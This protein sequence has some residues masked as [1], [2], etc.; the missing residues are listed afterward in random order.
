M[1][2]RSEIDGLRAIAVTS[3]VLFHLPK[4]TNIFGGG[5]LGVDIFFVISGYVISLVLFQEMHETNSISLRN[6]YLRRTRRLIPSF[7]VVVCFSI[8]FGFLALTPS[9]LVDF[10]K[11]IVSS[12]AFF[13]N[14]YFWRSTDYFSPDSHFRPFLHTWSLSLEEQFYLFFPVLLLILSRFKKLLVFKN[15]LI[16]LTLVSLFSYFQLYDIKPLAAFYLLPFRAWEL[17]IGALTFISFSRANKHKYRALSYFGIITLLLL[18]ADPYSLVSKLGVFSNVVTVLSTS[19]VLVSSHDNFHLTNLLS[20]RLLTFIGKSS[21]EIYLWHFP[22]ISFSYHLGAPKSIT[23]SLL[24]LILTFALGFMTHIF[25]GD[26]VRKFSIIPKNKDLVRSTCIISLLI[27]MISISILKSDGYPSRF[28]TAVQGE[29][30]QRFFYNDMRAKSFPCSPISIYISALDYQGFKRCRQSKQDTNPDV[31]LLG[32][33]TAESLFPG[34]SFAFHDLNVGYY[35]SSGIPMLSNANFDS[36]FNTLLSDNKPKV[37]LLTWHYFGH[38]PMST[39]VKFQINRTIDQLKKS[40]KAIFIISGVPTFPI[41]AEKCKYTNI[42]GESNPECTLSSRQRME[43]TRISILEPREIATSNG[44]PFI[45]IFSRIC[46]S[47]TCS[48]ILQEKILYRDSLHLNYL[49]SQ[50]VATFLNST[51]KASIMN[52]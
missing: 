35:V 38:Y 40:N 17:M 47:R 24:I 10:A 23:F 11:S 26:R 31:V 5:F 4:S 22:L 1:A 30:G 50:I 15:V 33:S 34:L 21:Y 46:N 45:N 6:F 42:L 2:Y 48:M 12:L 9:A 37:V 36:I 28:S 51:F 32:D 20:Y 52:S 29:V 3:V 43:Q 27:Y 41:D 39:S 8:I 7:L 25:V 13:S 14:F 16:V 19:I 18:I 49:G 44:V